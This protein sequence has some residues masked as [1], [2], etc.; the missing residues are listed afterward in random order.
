MVE[1][2]PEEEFV[3]HFLTIKFILLFGRGNIYSG[4]AGLTDLNLC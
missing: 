2:I 4:G 1:E 3:F